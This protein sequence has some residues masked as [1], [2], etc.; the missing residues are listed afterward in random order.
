[1]M[2]ILTGGGWLKPSLLALFFWGLWGFLTKLGAEKVPWQTMMIFFA[3]CT[4]AGGLATGP[5]KMKM[6]VWHLI[7]LGAGIAGALGFI[8]FFLAISRG[9][10]SVVIPITSLYVAVASVLAFIIL[11]EPITLKKMLGILCAVIAVVLL[12]G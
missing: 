8:Y 10:A 6:D 5:V 7:G 11:S 4:L 2:E 3:V 1:M 12:A 9:E